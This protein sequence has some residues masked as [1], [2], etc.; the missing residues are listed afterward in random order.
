MTKEVE[1][2]T[3]RLT[4]ELKGQLDECRKRMGVS[5]NALVVQIL[6][7]WAERHSGAN[8]DPATLDRNEGKKRQNIPQK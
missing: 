2:F 6:W 7:D 4:G 8:R 1:R 3:L 5:M